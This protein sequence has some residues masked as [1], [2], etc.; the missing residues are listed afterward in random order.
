MYHWDVEHHIYQNL[1]AYCILRNETKLHYE[2]IFA[3]ILSQMSEVPRFARRALST[4][5]TFISFYSSAFQSRTHAALVSQN[6][7]L[8]KHFWPFGSNY[9]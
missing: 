5:L 4:W 1:K 9:L 6:T 7:N 8:Y 3:Q 2:S